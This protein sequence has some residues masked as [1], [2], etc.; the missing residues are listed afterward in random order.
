MVDYAIR[1]NT[2]GILEKTLAGD[3]NPIA[4][5]VASIG[6][7]KMRLLPGASVLPNRKT[8]VVQGTRKSM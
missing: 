3:V 7:N 1:M 6:R 4:D 5:H 8:S 2:M